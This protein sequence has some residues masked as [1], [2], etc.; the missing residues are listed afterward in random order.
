MVYACE[1]PFAYSGF[2]QSALNIQSPPGYEMQW[3][4]GQGWCIA[5]CRSRAME[6]ALEW[7]ADLICIVDADHVYDPD[8]M[9]RLVER[10]DKDGCGMV[11]PMI[12]MRGY[13]AKLGFAKPFDKIGWRFDDD[14]RAGRVEMKDG[15]IIPIDP[16]D[17][18]L[19]RAELP[20]PGTLLFPASALGKLRKPWLY[21]FV[22]R[23]NFSIKGGGDTT[24]VRRLQVEA[25]LESWVDTT[26]EVK[27]LNVFEIDGSYPER[28]ADWAEPG[29]GDPRLC[30]VDRDKR[31]D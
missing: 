24:F 29:V 31:L 7:D 1:S 20:S 26:I 14:L 4:R 27:H 11:A 10:I 28:F 18:E 9:V 8:V 2:M 6:Q 22:D 19:Q 15:K 3:F 21:E 25:G 12:P 17:G 5:R 30:A 23:G 16:A 13:V